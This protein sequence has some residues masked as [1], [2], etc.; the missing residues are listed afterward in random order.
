MNKAESIAKTYGYT[1]KYTN[2]GLRAIPEESKPGYIP[3]ISIYGDI[4]K[5]EFPL[6]IPDMEYT[7]LVEFNEY[8]ALAERCLR[9]LKYLLID[10]NK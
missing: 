4:A 7:E 3:E 5:V 2:N 1:I 6:G 10:I 8:L 9:E